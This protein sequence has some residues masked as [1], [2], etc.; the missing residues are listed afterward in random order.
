MMIIVN[1]AVQKAT[2]SIVVFIEGLFFVFIIEEVKFQTIK[3]V[4]HVGQLTQLGAVCQVWYDTSSRL[5]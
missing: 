1:H 5:M 3:N 4:K 2:I